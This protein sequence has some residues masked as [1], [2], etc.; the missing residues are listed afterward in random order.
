MESINDTIVAAA[1]AETPL[2]HN[3]DTQGPGGEAYDLAPS[4]VAS[5]DETRLLLTERAERYIRS[6]PLAAVA[7]SLGGGLLV[8]FGARLVA[9]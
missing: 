1:E 8:G 9:R 4:P 2:A 7:L 5:R 6:R 3:L